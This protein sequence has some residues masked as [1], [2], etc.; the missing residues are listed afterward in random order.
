[1]VYVASIVPFTHMTI[2]LKQVILKEP[3]AELPQIVVDNLN[4]FYGTQEIGV[5]GQ[6][7]SMV[8][9]MLMTLLIGFILLYFA[10]RNMNKKMG[11]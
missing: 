7:V 10:Y 6:S 4:V 1:M 2:L 5:F 11:K 9:L 8:F 3:Y